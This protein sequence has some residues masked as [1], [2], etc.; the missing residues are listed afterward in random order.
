MR[1]VGSYLGYTG[2]AANFVATAAFDPKRSSH[3][4][5]ENTS[6]LRSDDAH[7]GGSEIQSRVSHGWPVPQSGL[8]I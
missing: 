4:A 3:W 8:S 1:Q 5:R 2:R 6:A 7:C